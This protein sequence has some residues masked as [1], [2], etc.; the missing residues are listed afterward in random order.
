MSVKLEKVYLL[1]VLLYIDSL[2]SVK[3]FICINKKC[4]EVSTML[5]L[6]T[7]RRPKDSDPKKEKDFIRIHQSF[8]VNAQKIKSVS[9]DAVLLSNDFSLPVSKSKATKVKEAYLWSKR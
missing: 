3:K 2:E 7:K 5:R 8:L 4:Q 6:Y 1:N 9:K